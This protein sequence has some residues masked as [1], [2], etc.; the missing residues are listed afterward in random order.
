MLQRSAADMGNQVALAGGSPVCCAMCFHVDISSEGRDSHRTGTI[1]ANA[2]ALSMVADEILLDADLEKEL[3]NEVELWRLETLK[4]GASSQA[5]PPEHASISQLLVSAIR[6]KACTDHAEKCVQKDS[7]SEA[8]GPES[9]RDGHPDAD[10]TASSPHS[11][12]SSFAGFV[13]VPVDRGEKPETVR[14]RWRGVR[15]DRFPF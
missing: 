11:H 9:T 4:P 8:G 6:R 15:P 5:A 1:F 13:E 3:A 7:A 12:A 14:I 10:T 2:S